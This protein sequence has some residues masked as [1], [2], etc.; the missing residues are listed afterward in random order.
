MRW[1]T[2]PSGE[3]GADQAGPMTGEYVMAVTEPARLL[4]LLRRE[5]DRMR[6][7]GETALAT[8]SRSR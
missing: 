1:V 3:R 4:D 6:E 8:R 5:P 7:R 2:F